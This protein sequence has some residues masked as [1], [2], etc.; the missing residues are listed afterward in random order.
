[1]KFNNECFNQ[2]QLSNSIIK[3]VLKFNYMFNSYH[4]QCIKIK[5]ISSIDFFSC[6]TSCILQRHHNLI[7]N[8][9]IFFSSK[10]LQSLFIF[11]YYI[12]FFFSLFFFVYYNI[13]HIMNIM[14]L[15]LKVIQTL[16]VTIRKLQTEIVKFKI[17]QTSTSIFSIDDNMNSSSVS[18][19]EKF[20]D[21][22]MFSDNQKKLHSFITKLYLKLERNTN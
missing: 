5:V 17:S 20:S 6:T 4:M 8:K 7:L 16:F 9:I 22:F 2:I 1:M 13:M 14:I 12:A 18:K 19:S 11:S 3:N 10:F 21:L 15:T